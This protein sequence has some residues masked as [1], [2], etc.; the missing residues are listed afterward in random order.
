M[1]WVGKADLAAAV[2]NAGGLGILTALT[3]PSPADL[4]REI[5]RTREMTDKPFGVNLTILP[6]IKPPPYREYLAAIIDGGVKI[7]ETAGNSPRDFID[8][9]KENGITVVHKC[10]T[11]RHALAAERIGVDIVSIDGFEC[12]GHPGEDDV[13]GLVLIPLAARALKIPV[14]ASGGIAD[15]RGMAAA[16]ALGAEGINMGTRFLVSREAPVH[17]NIKQALVAASERDTRLMFRTMNN[18]TRVLRN[19]ISEEVVATERRPGGCTFEE[20]RHLVAGTRGRDAFASGAVDGGVVAAGQV[21]GLI[22]D[23]PSCAEL[24]ER[25]V[26][27]CRQHLRRAAHL[28]QA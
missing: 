20:I 5:G 8:R 28:A 27:D 9:L 1:Q 19:A 18:T 2:S 7:L 4:A 16:L 21:V 24:I 13:P 14:V 15:G 11:I 6:T 22:D 3:Q 17:H 10:T 26:V 12:A 25:I 23:I